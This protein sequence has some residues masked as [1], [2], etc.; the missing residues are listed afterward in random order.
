MN[1]KFLII[2]PF[3]LLIGSTGLLFYK[4]STTGEWFERSVELKGGDV[5]TVSLKSPI[6]L[7]DVEKELSSLGH[8][9]VRESSG[10]SGNSLF[11]QAEK[12]NE[13]KFL[14]KLQSIGIN[15]DSYS[16][17]QI[18]PSLGESF[19]TQVQ[20]GIVVAFIVMGLIVF[21]IFRTAVPSAGVMLAAISDILITLALMQVFGIELSLASFAALLMLIGYSVDTDILLTTRLLKG[22]EE[23]SERVKSAFKTGITMTL[24]SISVVTVLFLSQISVVL[25]QIA[26]V[27]LIGLS[28]DIIMTWLQN[29]PLLRWHIERREYA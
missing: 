4:Y 28:I 2:I 26:I 18:G 11:I 20:I 16:I 9:V 7:D 8:V 23:I 10:F 21:L 15:T 6:N 13:K 27:L 25:S 5:L 1:Y 19:W 17:R 22:E 24:T 12:I 14:S 3:I 29:M